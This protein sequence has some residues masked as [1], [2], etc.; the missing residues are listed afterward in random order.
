MHGSFEDRPPPHA[1]EP[2]GVLVSRATEQISQ[3]VREELLLAQAEMKQKG[4]RFG[5]GGG[6][7]GAAG[8]VALLALQA[9]VATA[10]IALALVLPWWASALVVT[11]AL[12]LL[13]GVLAVI[14]R[15]QVK[16]GTP[17]VP[18][19]AVEGVKTDVAEVKER[20]HR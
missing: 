5:I 9:M 12:L 18:R 14:G 16:K 8:L 19:R 11:G 10:V 1:G 13:A 3:L 15:G 20:A 7:F 2:V 17:P 4:K 6:M